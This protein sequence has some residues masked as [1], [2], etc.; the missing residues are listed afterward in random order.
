MAGFSDG[1]Q[2]L[3]AA[4]KSGEGFQRECLVNTVEGPRWHFA[5]R[6]ADHRPGEWARSSLLQ[7]LDIH[8]RRS[9]EDTAEARARLIDE[10]SH[11]VAPSSSSDKRSCALGPDPDVGWQTAAVP[12]IGELTPER[13]AEI[14]PRLLEAIQSQRKRRDPRS[15][16][17]QRGRCRRGTRLVRPTQ[18]I[19]L[20][21]RSRS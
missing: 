17:L 15:D 6:H 14:S 9:V 7:Q 12:L 1:A 5:A 13:L 20:L 10:L 16:R 8:Q 11:N 19:G 4:M 21:G 18:A 2:A 3:L